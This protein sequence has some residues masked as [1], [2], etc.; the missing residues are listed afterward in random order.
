MGAKKARSCAYCGRISALTNEHVFPECFRKTFEA[1][2]IAKTPSGDRAI[3]SALE[4]H[5]V[6]A[7]CNNGPLSKLDTY[8]CTLNDNYFSNI[9][10][11]GDC[12]RFEY[13]FD[14]LLKMLL[15]IGF[16]V[17]RARK[18]PYRNWADVAKCIVEGEPCPS[19][20]HLFLQLLVPTPIEKTNLPVTDGTTE[21]PPVPLRSFLTNVS[22]LPGMNLE[23]AISVWSYRFFILREDARVPTKARKYMMAKWLKTTK[24]AYELT[25]SGRATIYASSVDVLSDATDSTIFEHQLSLARDLKSVPKPKKGRA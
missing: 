12:V 15:K 7:R 16:N 20:F 22:A 24:G 21:I 2:S 17:A 10:H 4:I 25:R 5:D 18:W 8:L 9:V 14:L 23:Y 13:D 3:Y 19:E 1:I 11:P 6:C